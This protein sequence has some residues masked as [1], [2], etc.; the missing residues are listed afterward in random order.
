MNLETLYVRI[1]RLNIV[2][3][4]NYLGYAYLHKNNIPT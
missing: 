3:N 2:E 4:L 1:Y